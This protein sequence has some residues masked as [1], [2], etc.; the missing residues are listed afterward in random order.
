MKRG[1]KWFSEK[2]LLSFDT[3]ACMTKREQ[4]CFTHAIALKGSGRICQ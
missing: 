1:E 2:K 4:L 3:Q